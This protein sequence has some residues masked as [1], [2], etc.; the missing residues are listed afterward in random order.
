MKR[1]YLHS[2]QIQDISSLSSLTNMLYLDLRNNPVPQHQVENLK[3]ALP[4]C[5]IYF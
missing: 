4:K 1:I 3:E 5:Y 2:N